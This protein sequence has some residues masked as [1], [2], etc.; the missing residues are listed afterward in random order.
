MMKRSLGILALLLMAAPAWAAEPS[1]D[2]AAKPPEEE[3]KAS[4]SNAPPPPLE[5]I[6]HGFFMEMRTGLGY[7]VAGT[8]LPSDA[9]FPLL[10]GQPEDLGLGTVVDLALGYEIVDLFALQLV[11]G[12][13]MVNGTR[14][15]RVRGLNLAYGGIGFRLNFPMAERWTVVA[16]ANLL[17]TRADTVVDKVQTGLGLDAS[18][19]FE[20]YVHVRHISL[21]ADLTGVVPFAPARL[22]LAVVP[23][24]R[25][26][27]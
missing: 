18:V 6:V 17:Y 9:Y 27:F 14:S 2:K 8:K 26:T 4:K 24:V 5:D 21:G 13:N 15:D 25:Y 7:M 20:Y 16:S 11:G 19:G 23:H 10:A 1:P 12:M 22:F 3:A